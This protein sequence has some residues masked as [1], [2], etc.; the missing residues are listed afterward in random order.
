MSIGCEGYWEISNGAVMETR[1]RLRQ[2]KTTAHHK[3]AL[4]PTETEVAKYGRGQVMLPMIQS[5]KASIAKTVDKMGWVLVRKSTLFRPFTH[6]YSRANLIWDVTA[7]G[8]GIGGWVPI[9]NASKGYHGILLKW[10]EHY[11]PS[12]EALLIS[13]SR[14]VA[15]FFHDLYPKLDWLTLDLYTEINGGQPDFIADICET[16]PTPLA[17]RFGTVFCQATLEHV[18]DP[19]T[20]MRNLA[21]C[22]SK[23]GVLLLHT[24]TPPFMYHPC[25]RDYFRFNIDWFEDIEKYIPGLV[26]MEM[27][28]LDGHICCAYQ[29]A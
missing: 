1:H 24:H 19:M 2:A 25:P 28:A 21:S 16:L 4:D 23:N 26:L 20:A 3:Q 8:R 15:C 14:N 17:G 12:G 18:Y 13:E 5:V 6:K 29:R 10:F 7:G 22:L 9:P 11:H 27:V